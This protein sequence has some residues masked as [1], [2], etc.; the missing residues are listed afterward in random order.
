MLRLGEESWE[1]GPGDAVSRP[2]GTEL[3]HQFYNP[4][5]EACSVLMFG[6]MTGRGVEDV[7]RWPEIKRRLVIDAE[8]KR[9]IERMG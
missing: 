5:Q 9:T 3:P 1:L 7:V 6:V 8:G 4:F 2:A